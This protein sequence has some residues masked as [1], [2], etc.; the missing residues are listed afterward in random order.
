MNRSKSISILAKHNMNEF[1]ARK[2]EA[3]G[4]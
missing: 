1:R 2:R 4:Y 3:R